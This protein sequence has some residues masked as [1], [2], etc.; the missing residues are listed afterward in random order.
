MIPSEII[1]NVSIGDPS[2]YY[3][4]V[5][6]TTV[7]GGKVFVLRR[8]SVGLIGGEL[9]ANELLLLNRRWALFA[10]SAIVDGLDSLIL[11]PVQGGLA[12]IDTFRAFGP[13]TLLELK[14]DLGEAGSMD[15]GTYGAL[16][17]VRFYGQLLNP[18][19]VTLPWEYCNVE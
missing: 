19:N 17:Q 3:V 15:P 16:W 18:Q 11:N 5:V 12:S 9:R 7:T 6:N 8:I 1:V 10:N 13:N 14:K 4:T 2:P